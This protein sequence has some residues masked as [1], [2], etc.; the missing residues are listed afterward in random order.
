MKYFW[1]VWFILT[2]LFF[3]AIIA[4]NDSWNIASPIIHGCLIILLLLLMTWKPLNII[5][6]L[7]GTRGSIKTFLCL[8][9]I[10]NLVFSGI[11][12][13][14]FFSKAGIVEIN[15]QT[16]LKFDAFEEGKDTV[17]VI[18]ETEL[19][20][21]CCIETLKEIDTSGVVI[22][23]RDT[24]IQSKTPTQMFI[25]TKEYEYQ[26]ISYSTILQNTLL[27]SLIQE[28][29]E[30]FSTVAM[31]DNS[32]YSKT[33]SWVLILHLFFSWIFFGV[34]ISILYNKFRYES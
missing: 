33:F 17:K 3:A 6:G 11:Y 15:G 1:P 24:L 30:L 32:D 5:Y 8:L 26:R 4:S 22:S 34:F 13:Y 25:K 18:R 7:I 14:G 19:I 21:A 28:P 23:Q 20:Y 12:Y 2:I 29:T 31:Y 9:F 16:E 27:T 10:I